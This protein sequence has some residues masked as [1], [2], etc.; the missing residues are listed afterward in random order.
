MKKLLL[1]RHAKATH[2][3]G[4][5]DFERPLTD[6]GFRQAELIAAR[7][8]ANSIQPQILV[9]SPALRTLSTANVFSQVL[10]LQQAITDKAIY[11]A[12]ESALLKVIDG[13]PQDKDFIAL[14]GHN[15][16]ISQVLYYLSGAIREVPPCS[17]ALIEF[18]LD[19]W[20]E[21]Y[22]ATGKLAFYDTPGSL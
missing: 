8:Q 16:G 19:T 2:E 4:F 22:E 17:V 12:S 5:V 14:V 10:G 18:E 3:S 11:D 15:P 6:K 20:T 1:I 21:I 9:A 7:L 13:L